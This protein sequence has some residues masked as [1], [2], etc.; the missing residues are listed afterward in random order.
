MSKWLGVKGYSLKDTILSA[1]TRVDHD[2]RVAQRQAGHARGDS[3]IIY[4]G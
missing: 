4:L 2:N 3:T 1:L